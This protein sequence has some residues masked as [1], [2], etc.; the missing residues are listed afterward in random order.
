MKTIS[1][2]VLILCLMP[3]V[4]LG[5]LWDHQHGLIA[6][7]ATTTVNAQHTAY[8][9][10]VRAC[11]TGDT[12]AAAFTALDSGDVIT[13]V[14][15]IVTLGAGQALWV[16]I[17]TAEGS[18]DTNFAYAQVATAPLRVS[19]TMQIPFIYTHTVAVDSADTVDNRVVA[20]AA[21]SS[22]DSYV[23]TNL[24]CKLYIISEKGN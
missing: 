6:T 14:S 20:L 15:G 22:T 12:T 11:S 7:A 23:V 18:T 4:A 5:V 24:L 2:L 17:D 21:R 19:G 3:I 8:G 13:E 9:S 10:W 1:R 16:G